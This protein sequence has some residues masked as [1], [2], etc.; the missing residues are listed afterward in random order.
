MWGLLI[1]GAWLF[2]VLGAM[3]LFTRYSEQAGEGAV[4]PAVWPVET[5]IHPTPGQ[6]T[7]VML[8]H[9]M[10]PCTR[11]SLAD[12][13]RLLARLPGKVSAHVLFIRP[14]GTPVD[15]EQSDLWNRARAIPGVEVMADPDGVE[16]RRFS[17]ATSGEVLL[18][19][20]DGH[21]SFAGGITSARGHEGDSPGA[22]RIYDLVTTGH[23]E[24]AVAPVFGCPL[25]AP[26]EGVRGP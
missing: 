1:G 7:L 18:Y 26:A 20:P 11:A 8:A 25:S 14:Q 3:A 21:L 15:W 16:A 13:A 4:S 12:L 9:P 19:G 23:A 2:A 22:E 17:G 24:L 10:C 5:R 6:S